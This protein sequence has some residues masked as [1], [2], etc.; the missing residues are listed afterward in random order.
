[1]FKSFIKSFIYAFKGIISAILNERNMR[2]HIVVSAYVLWF[3][4]FYDFSKIE[5]AIL[6]LV[7][8]MVIV[9]EL[10][11]TAVESAVDMTSKSY[12]KYAEISKDAAAG[13]VLISAICAAAVGILFFADL[14]ILYEIFVY[15]K[16]SLFKLIILILSVMFSIAFIFFLFPAKNK[17]QY[18]SNKEK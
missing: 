12:N 13:A 11:N 18:D 14:N 3:S 1:M 10:V 15:F 17:K 8:A 7:I 2:F 4:K 5:Y 9:S 16:H 6:F